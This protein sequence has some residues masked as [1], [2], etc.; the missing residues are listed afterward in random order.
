[1]HES[2]TSPDSEGKRVIT[3]TEGMVPGIGDVWAEF[4]DGD[5]L[6]A[7]TRKEQDRK[8][9]GAQGRLLCAAYRRRRIGK[10]LE[11]GCN[12]RPH[13]GPLLSTL[14][15]NHTLASSPWLLNLSWPLDPFIHLATGQLLRMF[16]NTSDPHIHNW[17][18][19]P[20]QTSFSA[21]ILFLRQSFPSPPNGSSQN[22]RV[23]LGL[24][25]PSFSILSVIKF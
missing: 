15:P 3:I 8:M 18:G 4:E 22:L 23:T 14:S 10:C 17:L 5:K 19:I 20:I 24:F 2:L 7:Q 1:M 21:C 16:L 25:L 12:M 11:L 6:G 9:P 13:P